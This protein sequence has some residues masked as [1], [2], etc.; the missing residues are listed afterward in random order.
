MKGFKNVNLYLGDKRIVKTSLLI[1]NGKIKKIGDLIENDLI[2]LDDDLVVVPGF[3]DKHVHGAN[4]S[5]GMYPTFED[6]ENIAVTIPKEGVASFLATTMTQTE[7]E[8]DKALVNINDYIKKQ[9]KGA[10]VIGIHL[11]GPFISKKHKGAQVESAIVP[12]SVEQFKHYQKKAGDN[13]RQVTL[14]YEENG[15]ELI[16]YLVKN[17]IVAS[18]GHTD[19]TSAQ[20]KEAVKAGATSVTHCFNA[21]KGLHHREA[22]TVGGS[23]LCDELY[24]ELIADLIHVS[25]DAI[26]ILFKT[27]GKDRIVLIT[28]AMEAKHLP[29]GE[30][31]LGGQKVFVKDGAARL[32]DGTLAGSTLTMDVAMRNIKEVMG[33]N[34][35]EVVDLATVNPAKNL[36]IDHK[37]GYIKE[38]YDADFT[39]INSNFEIFK[40]ISKG[41]IIYEK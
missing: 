18:L 38:G 25:P 41:K 3:I 29:D 28:D 23:M 10:E 6:I 26:R 7:E 14:A 30:Y 19:A 22:G 8:I 37:K 2:S 16:K 15:E 27:K 31:S 33:M 1:E 12:C 20:V 40:T 17:N 9:S 5:D 36:K 11:E 34:Y 32:A 4:N 13:I 39:V 35:L 24:C 21:M